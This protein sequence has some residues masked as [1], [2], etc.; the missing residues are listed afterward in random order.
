MTYYDDEASQR[1]GN[2]DEAYD[3]SCGTSHW[4]LTSSAEIL[5]V[6]FNDYDPATYIKRGPIIISQNS[7]KNVLDINIDPEH[8]MVA[9]WIDL[10]PNKEVQLTIWRGHAGTNFI[11]YWKGSVANVAFEDDTF[12]KLQCIKGLNKLRR[13]G[14]VL[15]Y[16]RMCVLPLFSKRCSLNKWDY[17]ATGIIDTVNGTTLTSTTFATKSDGFFNDG[18]IEVGNYKRKIETHV[19]NTITIQHRIP[20]LAANDSFNAFAGCDHSPT[21]CLAYSNK[22]N[23]GGQEH[24][25]IKNPFT[26]DGI[27]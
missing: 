7:L 19:T 20:G 4:R 1:S 18:Y 26:G 25:P 6:D 23:Y 27:A 14:L 16:S 12:C 9:Q 5:T 8:P 17:Y 24:L 3:F 13:V 21:D 15:A 11:Q 22:K 10:P 2:P